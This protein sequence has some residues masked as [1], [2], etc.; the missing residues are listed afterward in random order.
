M[1]TYVM[2]DVHGAFD[3]LQEMLRVIQF[4][5]KDTLY[6][7]GDVVDRGQKGV[8]I[9][10][11]VMKTSGIQMILGNHEDMCMHFFEPDSDET[12]I[13]RWN[14]NGNYT[15][16]AGFDKV[17]EEEKCAILGFIRSLPSEI[18]VTVNGICYIL[19][20]GFLGDNTHERVWNR[21]KLDVKPDIGETER[22]IIGHTPVCEYVCPGSDEDMYVY[23]RSLTER[24]DHFR[25]LHVDGFTDIDCCV[26]YGMSA[27]RLACL[28]LEDGMEFYV[29]VEK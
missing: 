14:R 6:I 3:A 15:T 4:S 26:G 10:Q 8:E 20:H 24:G 16:L 1:A 12:V 17:S 18:R 22:I 29:K 13:R 23:S 5:E 27:A 28:R 7:L 11:F 25:I 21:P 2:S 9:L 19:V